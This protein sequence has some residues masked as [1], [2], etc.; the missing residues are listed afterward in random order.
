[1]KPAFYFIPAFLFC[2]CACSSPADP[3]KEHNDPTAEPVEFP[4]YKILEDNQVLLTNNADF[5][6]HTSLYGASSFLISYQNKTYAVTAKHLIGDA[7]EVFPE[8]KPNELGESIRNWKMFPRV[9]VHE[10]ADTVI[11]GKE[12]MNYDALTSDILM[13]PIENSAFDILPLKVRFDLPEAGDE[14]FIIGCPYAEGDCRQNIYEVVYEA[15]DAERARLIVTSSQKIVMD[16]FSGGPLVDAQGNVLGVMCGTIVDKG[17]F[18]IFY[19][20]I[21][22]I[23]KIK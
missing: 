2:L 23:E 17:R 22:E 18:Y 19:T 1:M 8:I 11:V 10:A 21:K 15:Y 4:V 20:F 14:L 5:I 9:Q 6:G 7:G 12:N 13:M 3:A 16:G